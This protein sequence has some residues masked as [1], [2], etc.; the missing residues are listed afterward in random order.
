[1]PNAEKLGKVAK[2]KLL[3]KD[4][5]LHSYKMVFQLAVK[6]GTACHVSR[7]QCETNLVNERQFTWVI[8]KSIRLFVFVEKTFVKAAGKSASPKSKVS[9]A[10][11]NGVKS[12]AIKK[13]K[14]S[15]AMAKVRKSPLVSVV[16]QSKLRN[17]LPH[18][19]ANWQ[20]KP[21]TKSI[22][23]WF[24]DSPILSL[25]NGLI[26]ASEPANILDVHHC[27]G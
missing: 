24:G 26:R 19:L 2:G 12:S 14:N 1:V 7:I 13:A 16:C 15:K 6:D 21:H 9:Q 20:S 27:P 25:Q 5:S 3:A 11:K 17:R 10:K 22:D 18:L 23:N 4:Y 8:H